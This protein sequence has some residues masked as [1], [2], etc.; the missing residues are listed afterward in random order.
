MYRTR[1]VDS[2]SKVLGGIKRKHLLKWVG[3]YT[4]KK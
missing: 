2:I 3:S 4:K 1:G